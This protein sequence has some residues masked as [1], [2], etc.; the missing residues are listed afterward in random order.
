M[1]PPTFPP[2][3]PPPTPYPSPILASEDLG[4]QVGQEDGASMQEAEWS[5]GAQAGYEKQVGCWGEA[6]TGRKGTAEKGHLSA[7]RLK[8][9]FV[10]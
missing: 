7:P 10:L 3:L 8:G 6:Q 5:Q 9:H 2:Q 4:R 1:P